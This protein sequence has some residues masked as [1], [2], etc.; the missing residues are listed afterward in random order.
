MDFEFEIKHKP[1]KDKVADYLS[2]NPIGEED[3]RKSIL[4]EQYIYFVAENIAP[5]ALTLERL[6]EESK[7]DR[8]LRIV[9]HIQQTKA[10][11]EAELNRYVKIWDEFSVYEG[12]IVLR[13]SRIVIPE[14]FWGEMLRIAHEGHLGVV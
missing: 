8:T 12:T 9:Q 13:G 14:E 4:A 7:N 1:G 3:C 2:R 6:I 5:R 11:E 10:P